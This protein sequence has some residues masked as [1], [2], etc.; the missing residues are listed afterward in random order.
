[1]YISLAGR[2]VE[3]TTF[4]DAA[5]RL[6]KI[7]AHGNLY[8]YPLLR[9]GGSKNLSRSHHVLTFEIVPF[10]K[11]LLTPTQANETETICIGNTISVFG[12]KTPFKL[13]T[14]ED[15]YTFEQLV[16]IAT[17]LTLAGAN[18]YIPS[19]PENGYPPISHYPI[20][21]FDP[22]QIENAEFVVSLVS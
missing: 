17:C 11:R 20:V 22:D 5:S 9:N 6:E 10:N 13:S 12:D 14:N 15:K 21:L 18:V 3:D 8:L 7:I 1:M 4:K 16:D 19:P 2:K